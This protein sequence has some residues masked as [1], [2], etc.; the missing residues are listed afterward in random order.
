LAVLGDGNAEF[1]VGVCLPGD[2]VSDGW[3]GK[4][5]D[6]LL[7]FF[8]TNESGLLLGSGTGGGNIDG[9]SCG[10]DCVS[11]MAGDISLVLS[12]EEDSAKFELIDDLRCLIVSILS[13]GVAFAIQMS[14]LLNRRIRRF[15]GISCCGASRHADRDIILHKA[16]MFRFSEIYYQGEL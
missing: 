10:D 15:N 3:I 1:C 8:D 16:D 2:T 13:R 12:L 4:L 9:S 11:G 5:I 14:S 7:L 6:N